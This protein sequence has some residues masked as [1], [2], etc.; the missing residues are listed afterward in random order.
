M[1]LECAKDSV[2][3]GFKQNDFKIE[4]NPNHPGLRDTYE[5]EEPDRP[6]RHA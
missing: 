5:K 3:Y 2:R 6:N 4:K 1:A